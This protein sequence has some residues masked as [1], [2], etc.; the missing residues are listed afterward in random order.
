MFRRSVVGI[1][2]ILWWILVLYIGHDLILAFTIII[3][4]LGWKEVI[5]V[6]YDLN[7]EKN[8]PYFRTCSWGIL[9]ASMSYVY[10]KPFLYYFKPAL[11]EYVYKTG[12]RFARPFSYTLY[13]CVLLAFILSLK[14]DTLKYQFTQLTWTLMT[15]LLVI[16]QSHF[17]VHNILGGLIWAV[18]PHSLIICNDIM[19]YFWGVAFG[20][21]FIPYSLTPL[22]P[23]KTWEGFLG[24]MVST[25]V[26]GFFLAPYI[27]TSD[28]I[29]CPK[30]SFHSIVMGCD[31]NPVFLPT[32][33]TL[34]LFL[35][36]SFGFETTINLLPIQ[37]HALFFALFA[38]VIA[39]F[40]GFLASGMKRAYGL[41]DFS[42]IFPGH[43]GLFDRLDCHLLM[44][45]FTYIYVT[46]FISQ[47]P[48]T[49]TGVTSML[50]TLSTSE[51]VVI[52]ET[53]CKN[54]GYVCTFQ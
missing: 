54:L 44:V 34:P 20:K 7:K 11:P 14:R 26:F 41:D 6:R 47:A 50:Y 2:M 30:T 9:F 51:Q 25:L 39:P 28:W 40:G 24:A 37:I 21:K 15:T 10:A 48:L 42:D 12:L 52:L 19:A 16:G 4:L 1:V 32:D 36:N 27:T 38:S 8:L 23:N 29:V 33:Y 22:S 3:Q 46:T 53:L 31:W 13:V 18:L 5:N 35:Q 17:V 45:T 43:G 49:V